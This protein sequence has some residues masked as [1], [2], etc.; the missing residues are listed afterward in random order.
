MEMFPTWSEII[1]LNPLYINKGK[2]HSRAGI[3]QSR[4]TQRQGNKYGRDPQFKILL[5]SFPL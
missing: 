4:A 1:P 3:L 5:Q 2:F